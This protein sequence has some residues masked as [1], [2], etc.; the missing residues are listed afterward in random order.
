MP[1]QIAGLIPGLDVRR[2]EVPGQAD[3]PPCRLLIAAGYRTAARA[4]KRGNRILRFVMLTRL[5]A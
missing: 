3:R 1:V 4:E 5:P 2:C